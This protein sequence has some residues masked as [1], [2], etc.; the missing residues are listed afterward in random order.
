MKT[1]TVRVGVIGAGVAGAMCAHLLHRAGCEV[2]VF[3]RAGAPGGRASSWRDESR[4]LVVDSGAAF[5]TSFYTRLIKLLPELGLQDEVHQLSRQ[6]DFVDGQRTMRFNAS[7]LWAATWSSLMLPNMGLIDK[8]RLTLYLA[9]INAQRKRLEWVTP[10]TL[11]HLDDRNVAQDAIAQVGERAYHAFIRQTLEP[12][13]F[14]PAEKVSRAMFVGM[15]ANSAGAQFYTFPR[16]ID[17]VSR[18]LLRGKKV[19]YNA[20][21]LRLEAADK[22]SVVHWRDADGEQTSHFDRIVCATTADVAVQLCQALPE[23]RLAAAQRQFL[24]QQRYCMNAHAAYL[25][26]RTQAQPVSQAVPAGPGA[27]DIVAVGM[28]GERYPQLRAAGQEVVSVYFSPQASQRYQGLS[29]A[30]VF[31]DVWTRA[32]DFY[33]GLPDEAEPLHLALRDRAIPEFGVG[34]YRRVVEFQAQQRA[35]L[36]FAGDYLAGAC[37]EGA[38]AS[39]ERAVAILLKG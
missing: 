6:V 23:H 15:M 32:R 29:E 34:H 20:E 9:R 24:Q 35:D 22:G 26:R 8:L 36:V 10:E 12:F 31:E 7:S 4:G 14:M 27:R 37:I 19:H 1:E 21:V 13:W 18:A 17:Q 30:K 16:G 2:E 11:V 39:A 38:L 5:F 33:P 25:I 28:G 3:E